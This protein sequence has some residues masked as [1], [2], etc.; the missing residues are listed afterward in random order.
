MCEI[1]LSI[2]DKIN[3]TNNCPGQNCEQVSINHIRMVVA[4]ITM[5]AD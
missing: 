3:S 4:I 1:K 2:S 5:I